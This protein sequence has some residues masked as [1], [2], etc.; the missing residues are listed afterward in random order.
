MK[1]RNPY[2]GWTILLALLLLIQLFFLKVFFEP[3]MEKPVLYLYPTENTNITVK[4]EHSEY[5]TTT[6]P[7][8]NDGWSVNV[9]TN[10]N[11]YDENG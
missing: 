9:D 10:G 11:L 5:L 2:K 4:F 7:K 3:L 1:N 6:Y 8:Y